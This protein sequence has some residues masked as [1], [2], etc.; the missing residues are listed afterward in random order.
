ML[1]VCVMLQCCVLVEV[2][3]NLCFPFR[4]W[5]CVTCGRS[6]I[7]K[8]WQISI[9]LVQLLVGIKGKASIKQKLNSSA[10]FLPRTN[11]LWMAAW[12]TP[13]IPHWSWPPPV[14]PNS[15]S[16]LH[17]QYY[18]LLRLHEVLPIIVS[19]H[20]CIAAG[21]SISWIRY[22]WQQPIFTHLQPAR[23]LVGIFSTILLKN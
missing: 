22:S 4:P 19:K 13:W 9:R 3:N 18:Q 5:F 14:W 10:V 12:S 1:C 16:F 20:H 23:I 21:F 6:W 2:S 7:L 15:G 8:G 17:V 11:K